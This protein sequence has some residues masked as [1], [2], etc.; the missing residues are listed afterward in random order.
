MKAATK[1]SSI[2]RY[3]CGQILK[4]LRFVADNYGELDDTPILL[5]DQSEDR[6]FALYSDRGGEGYLY[7]EDKEEYYIQTDGLVYKPCMELFKKTFRLDMLSD[8]VK[9]DLLNAIHAGQMMRPVEYDKFEEELLEVPAYGSFVWIPSIRVL[10]KHGISTL[11]YPPSEDI[12]LVH[13]IVH[14]L[15]SEYLVPSEE[16]DELDATRAHMA[17]VKQHCPDKYIDSL[18][19]LAYDLAFVCAHHI[20]NWKDLRRNEHFRARCTYL[21]GEARSILSEFNLSFSELVL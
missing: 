11:W 12:S 17:F 1:P 3:R 15:N 13:E 9:T 16:E 6:T 21:R 20:S 18:A 19:S 7:D 5:L 10:R 8:E 14:A 4:A 2:D